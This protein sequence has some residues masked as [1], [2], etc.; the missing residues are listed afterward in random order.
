MKEEVDM[1]Q[2]EPMIACIVFFF[3]SLTGAYVLFKKLK[4]TGSMNTPGRS[5]G[6]AIVGFVVIFGLLF[7]AYD[8]LRGSV[9]NSTY[10]KA[11]K[12]SEET[13][14]KY[15]QAIS[16]LKEE[17]KPQE[18]TI[19]GHIEIENPS[20]SDKIDVRYQPPSPKLEII[21][22]AHRFYLYRVKMVPIIGWPKF[23]F[24]SIIFS[25]SIIP[26]DFEIDPKNDKIDEKE[27]VVTLK[28]PIYIK[29][30]DSRKKY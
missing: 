26:E 21:P 16:Q 28:S 24:F 17:L 13:V 7:Y 18:W 5:L 20:P 14:K 15:E 25:S 4:S 19:T 23:Q 9:S 10:Q 12:N 29:K 3:L 27:K 11:I 6:G 30:D 1:E 8:A 2:Y 22:Q